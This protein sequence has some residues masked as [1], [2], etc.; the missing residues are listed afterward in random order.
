[1]ISNAQSQ[2]SS[3]AVLPGIVAVWDTNVLPVVHSYSQI[4]S[5]VYQ[6]KVPLWQASEWPPLAI[7]SCTQQ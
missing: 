4:S 6:I 1:M 2:Y 3:S 5:T 7:Q